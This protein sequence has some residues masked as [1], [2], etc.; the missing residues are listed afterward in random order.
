MGFARQEYWSEVPLPSPS[1]DCIKKGWIITSGGED[2][3]KWESPS[4]ADGNAKWCSHFETQLVVPQKIKHSYH[5]TKQ[6]NS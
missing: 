3:G 2:V 1:D 6:V 4:F 5:M